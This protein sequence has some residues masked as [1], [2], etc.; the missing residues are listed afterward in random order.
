MTAAN[1]HLGRVLTAALLCVGLGAVAY[2]ATPAHKP[3]SGLAH[4]PSSGLS[5][6]KYPARK[7]EIPINAP[8]AI[9]I[10]SDFGAVLYER[11][12]DKLIFPASLGKLMTVEYVFHLLKEGRLNLTD[13]F[14]VS[15]NAWRKGG[16]PSH[17]SS[18]FVAL[19]SKV[20]VGDLLH[21]AIVQSG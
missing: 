21:G 19:H 2:A 13:E 18:M 20:A 16:A 9:L 12:P 5:A 8:H 10:D 1:S 14:H 6:K 11:D 17:T 7:D 15:E 3:G 4:R